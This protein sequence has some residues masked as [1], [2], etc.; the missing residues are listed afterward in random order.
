MAVR[1]TNPTPAVE[2]TDTIPET[3]D[4]EMTPEMIEVAESYADARKAEL[5]AA[6]AAKAKAEREAVR[7]AALA[8]FDDLDEAVTVKAEYVRGPRAKDIEELTHP[9][10]K[11]LLQE[12]VDAYEYVKVKVTAKDENGNLI[13]DEDGNYVTVEEPDLTKAGTPLWKDQK[14]PNTATGDEFK[15]QIYAYCKAKGWKPSTAWKNE[16]H[17]LLRFTAKVRVPADNG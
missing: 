1:K 7:H 12:C 14:F 16:D 8:A 11:S 4:L 5:K 10:V 9:R 13:E 17:T 2:N 6:E 3:T 15:R